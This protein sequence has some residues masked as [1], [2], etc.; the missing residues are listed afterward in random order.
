EDKVKI[1]VLAEVS[2]GKSTLLNSLLFKKKILDARIGETTAKL[3]Y[4][5]YNDTY[6]LDDKLASDEEELKAF[7]RES[8]EKFLKKFEKVKL[9]Q[10]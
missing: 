6:K 5:R 10:I 2:N 3:Y 9:Q 4:I 1:S 7:I 8:N